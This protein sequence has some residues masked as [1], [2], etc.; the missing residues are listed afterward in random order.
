M[1]ECTEGGHC[2]CTDLVPVCT[3]FVGFLLIGKFTLRGWWFKDCRKAKVVITWK[4]SG[5]NWPPMKLVSLRHLPYFMLGLPLCWESILCESVFSEWY[6]TQEYSEN[7]HGLQNEVAKFSNFDLYPWVP[8]S[9][10]SWC[11]KSSLCR[12]QIHYQ[13]KTTCYPLK[14]DG[15]SK[16]MIGC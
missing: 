13:M 7:M 10:S 8:I 9:L 6:S 1:G 12:M 4:H 5:I 2:P 16:W 14:R 3:N 11:R 15:A